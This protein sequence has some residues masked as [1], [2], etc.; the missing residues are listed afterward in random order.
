MDRVCDG[1]MSDGGAQRGCRRAV[2]WLPTGVVGNSGNGQCGKLCREAR[3]QAGKIQ[4]KNIK[5]GCVW[6]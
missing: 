3:V 6:P 4:C 1:V 5:M 2:Y